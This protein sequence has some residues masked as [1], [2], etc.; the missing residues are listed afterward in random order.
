MKIDHISIRD[1]QAVKAIDIDLDRPALLIA[2]PNEQG[3]SS[4]LDAVRLAL[5]D[6]TD[7]VS[8]KKDRGALVRNGAK[9]ATIAI[10]GDSWRANIKIPGKLEHGNAPELTEAHV[11]SL[12]PHYFASLKTDARR[13]FLFPILGI[14]FD[15]E[16]VTKRVLARGGDAE[17]LA[18]I[19]Q[20][21]G[22]KSWEELQADAKQY[23]SKARGAWEQITGET[24]G[25][26]KAEG[27]LP[28][29]PSAPGGTVHGAALAIKGV[30]HEIGEL[31][32]KIGAL[33]AQTSHLEARTRKLAELEARVALVD[34]RT[35]AYDTARI[36]RAAME[37][38]V[39]GAKQIIAGHPL[40]TECSCPSCGAV[41]LLE[42][43]ALREK[44]SQSE[45]SPD[46]I[47]EAR[48]ALP[49]FEKSLAMLKAAEAN[50][51][52][53]LDDALAAVSALA[54]LKANAIEPVDEA[55]MSGLR[56]MLA[57]AN[58]R[59]RGYEQAKT[60]IEAIEKAIATAEATRDSAAQRH[61]HVVEWTALAELIGPSGVPGELLS[62][63]LEPFNQKLNQLALLAGWDAPVIRDDMA[64]EVKGMPYGLGSVSARY[65][66]DVLLSIAIAVFSGTKLVV[67]DGIEV[68]VGVRRAQLLKLMHE[69]AGTVLDTVIL[70]AT[71]KEKPK[72]P[73]SYRVVWVEAGEI[74]EEEAEKVAA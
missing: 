4:I 14:K 72:L 49:G 45:H 42:G 46:D 8:T 35:A 66:T 61:R 47:A 57:D 15:A 54:E 25:S 65:R 20:H 26:Q 34:R 9:A 64:I 29:V 13:A 19:A 68:L 28:T 69:L 73:A 60:D 5:L 53:D 71:L 21:I 67:L 58:T 24:Y 74:V 27:W 18:V 12:C 33:N 36:D 32:Q 10:G 16:S 7:R 50:A 30:D 11:S 63:G 38:T 56:T 70:A 41:L 44:P 6:D 23:A 55:A 43:G 3:K 37:G 31:N 52:R 39:E 59:R 62:E 2:G 51:K 22:K 48:R 1:F 40:G 17:K